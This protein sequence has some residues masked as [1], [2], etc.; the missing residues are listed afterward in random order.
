MTIYR[1]NEYDKCLFSNTHVFYIVLT[2]HNLNRH[3]GFKHLV[4]WFKKPI[5][6][7]TNQAI[8]NNIN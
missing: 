8:I 4:N 7:Y 1:Y 3:R 2:D 5:S 6:I